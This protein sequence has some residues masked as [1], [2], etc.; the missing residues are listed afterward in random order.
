MTVLVV[1]PRSIAGASG[2]D[3]VEVCAPAHRYDGE[4]LVST[5]VDRVPVESIVDIEVLPGP[6]LVR[7]SGPDMP[8][9]RAVTV[10]VP[11]VPRVHLSELIGDAW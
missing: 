6:L 1:A 10:V 11:D 4:A 9:T 5:A 3:F 7:L 2:A 8:P